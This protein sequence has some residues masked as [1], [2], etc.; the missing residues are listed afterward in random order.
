MYNLF[1]IKLFKMYFYI[2]ESEREY[3]SG[4]RHKEKE[5]GKREQENFL[6]AWSLSQGL[7]SWYWDHELSQNEASESQLIESPRCPSK[8]KIKKKNSCSLM[9]RRWKQTEFMNYIIWIVLFYFLLDWSCFC[10]NTNELLLC[11]FYLFSLSDRYF[12]F[13]L[14]YNHRM[15]SVRAFILQMKP[16]TT[17]LPGMLMM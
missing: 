12:T 17:K 11:G 3:T 5:E 16:L 7:I 13:A 6:W 15:S 1:K 4:G 2:L 10:T 14:N 9:K 8:S